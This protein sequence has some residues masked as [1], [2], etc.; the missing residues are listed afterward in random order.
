[1][2]FKELGGRT[3][4][5]DIYKDTYKVNTELRGV[6]KD[7]RGEESCEYKERKWTSRRQVVKT[8]KGTNNPRG[9]M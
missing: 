6:N 9:N 7:D 5:L 4:S 8:N 1:M 2:T 3:V